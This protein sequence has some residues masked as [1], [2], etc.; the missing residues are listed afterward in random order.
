MCLAHGLLSESVER[1]GLIEISDET[2]LALSMS[3][4]HTDVRHE[5]EHCNTRFKRAT[6]SSATRCREKIESGE[7]L[8][9][10]RHCPHSLGRAHRIFDGKL[11]KPTVD[12]AQWGEYKLY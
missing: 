2:V 12:R 11:N 7:L 6:S 5:L 8:T 3:V 9:A 10:L 4:C 1:M